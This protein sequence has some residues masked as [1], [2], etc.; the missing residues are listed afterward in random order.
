MT[1]ATG[2]LAGLVV[3]DFSRVLAG[4][5]ATMML[6]DMG[7]E[8]IKIERPGFGDDTRSWGPPRDSAGTATYFN[9]VN[10]NKASRTIDLS[11]D[12]GRAEAREIVA[13]ADI[14][15][16]NFRSGTMERLGLGYDELS[17]VDPRLIY[18]SITGFGTAQGAA[19][20]GYDLL[21]QATSGLMSVT[22]PHADSPTKSGVAL[23]DV[24]TGVH[25]LSGILAAL[26]ERERSGLGQRVATN[27]F[28]TALSSLV[29][30]GSAFLG[31]GVVGEAIGNRHPSIAPYEE[32]AAADRAIVIAVGNDKQFAALCDELGL[33]E[34]ASDPR[35]TTNSDRV[36][37]RAELRALLEPPITTAT[38]DEWFDRFA[39]RAVPAGPINSIAEAFD[40]ADELGLTSRVSIPGA[41][42]EQTA[43]P[44]EFSRTPV[45]YR[46]PPPSL[47]RPDE[48]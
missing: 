39:A 14:L 1:A 29:N 34:L 15:V 13:G 5:Y 25:A 19:L 38:A 47:D 28:S 30:Q 43:N 26:H 9:S 16:E 18:C 21:V 4:P 12:S 42:A 24:L 32:F 8:V 35:F 44:I 48:T 7:A 3:A 33:R 45:S 31:A 2:P 37:H 27:L 6:A 41:C 10:R 17:R 40:F 20:P 11:A 46:L 22:G 23:V 36:A